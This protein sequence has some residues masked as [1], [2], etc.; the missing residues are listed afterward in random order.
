MSGVVIDTSVAVAW[1]F[2]DETSSTATRAIR[3]LAEGD[4]LVPPIFEYEIASALLAAARRGRL[5]E[6]QARE[7]LRD[8]AMLPLQT[9]HEGQSADLLVEAAHRHELSVYDVAYLIL[10]QEHGAALAS[11]DRRLRAAAERAGVPLL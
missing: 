2:P 11:E 6:A 8:I 10:A 5:S 9:S 3:A 4:G 1:G 7:S